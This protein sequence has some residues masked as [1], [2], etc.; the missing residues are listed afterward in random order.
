M[1]GWKKYRP[2]VDCQSLI[3]E[4]NVGIQDIVGETFLTEV[5]YGGDSVPD[6]N[7]IGWTFARAT[8]LEVLGDALPLF[9]IHFG[10]VR[11]QVVAPLG[12]QPTDMQHTSQCPDRVGSS[13]VSEEED[14]ITPIVIVHQVSV[15]FDNI[16]SD[17]RSRDSYARSGLKSLGQRLS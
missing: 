9:V 1:E 17:T 2:L 4:A 10:H 11:D 7:E 15:G 5:S 13:A 6:P 8:V 14:P 3:P 12:K 16:L